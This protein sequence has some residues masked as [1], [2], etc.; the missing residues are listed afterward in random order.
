MSQPAVT[1]TLTAVPVQ[2]P[3]TTFR[4]YLV[5]DEVDVAGEIAQAWLAGVRTIRKWTLTV[6]DVHADTMTVDAV[7]R[8]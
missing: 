7:D 1:P 4:P 6:A 5:P 2:A 8:I 3:R